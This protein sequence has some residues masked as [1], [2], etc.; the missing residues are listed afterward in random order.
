MDFSIFGCKSFWIQNL[1]KIS[2]FKDFCKIQ[3]FFLSNK[4]SEKCFVNKPIELSPLY[5]LFTSTKEL[6]NFKHIAVI[7]KIYAVL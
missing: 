7:L 3:R 4:I 1:D 2:E 6:L 5:D